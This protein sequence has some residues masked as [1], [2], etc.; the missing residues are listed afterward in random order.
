MTKPTTPFWGD[1]LSKRPTQKTTKYKRQAN[2]ATTLDGVNVQV[3]TTTTGGSFSAPVLNGVEFDRM[4]RYAL[5]L[6]K[7]SLPDADKYAT[8]WHNPV[9]TVHMANRVVS[10]MA[11]KQLFGEDPSDGTINLSPYTGAFANPAGV[12]PDLMSAALSLLGTSAF[13]DLLKGVK[14]T[15]PP[16]HEALWEIGAKILD[17]AGSVLGE[18][19]YLHSSRP[20]YRRQA[21]RQYHV[22]ANYGE[23]AFDRYAANRSAE[24]ARSAPKGQKSGAGKPGS[25]YE[26]G[27]KRN[28]DGRV[29]RP[30]DE[31]NDGGWQRPYLAKHPLVL[32]HTGKA[33]RRM[34]ATNEGKYPKMFSR[35]VTDPYRRIFQRKTR[36]LGGVVVF[37]C[38]GSMNLSDDDIKM[39][40]RASSGCSIVCYSGGGSEPEV[41]GNIHLVARHGRQMRGL[42]Y[43]PG[44][45]GVD[46]PAIKWAYYNLRLNSKSPVIWVS[47]GQVTGVGD[48]SHAN[49]IDM[50]QRFIKQKHITQ[51]RDIKE[52]MTLL[53]QLQRKKMS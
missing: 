46:L 33:G 17:Y 30:I 31:Y 7:W 10:N 32:P 39:V 14:R 18:F 6:A 47:D 37:D 3:S 35:L 29:V 24:T 26:A 13:D 36:S 53:S 44:D 22:I 50:T 41:D 20:A 4:R 28:D 1:A 19:K 25:I 21:E 34:V 9:H 40:M 12:S 38:S 2:M 23:Q 42:P 48:R 52:A 49:L 45:N 11:F 5:V 27:D 8:K 15:N 51:V 16:A 43:F